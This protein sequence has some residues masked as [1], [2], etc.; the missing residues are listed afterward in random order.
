MTKSAFVGSEWS[1]RVQHLSTVEP[2]DLPADPEAQAIKGQ[3][4]R[5]VTA[6]R[7]AEAAKLYE[8]A[9]ALAPID[10][11][12]Y[13]SLSAVLNDAKDHAAARQALKAGIDKRP[14]TVQPFDGK[15]TATVLKLIGVQNCLLRTRPGGRYVEGGHFSTKYLIDREKFHIINFYV[16]DG[17]LATYS[18]IPKFDIIVN[19]IADPDKEET[20]LRAVADFAKKFPDITIINDPNSVILTT[21]DGNFERLREI[22]GVVIPKTVRISTAGMNANDT[23]ERIEREDFSYPILLREPGW[24]TGITF[25][26]ANN[27]SEVKEYVSGNN[28]D[29]IYVTQFMDS[30][31]KGV[32]ALSRFFT[33]HRKMR[34]LCVDGQI[35]PIVC[36]IDKSWNVHRP[37]GS[38]KA[39][40]IRNRWMREEEFI[41][42]SDYELYI[43][44]DAADTLQRVCAHTELDFFGIDFNVLPDGRVLIFELN[45]AMRH[46]FAHGE[47]FSYVMPQL[48]AV[49][50]GFNRML[51]SKLVAPH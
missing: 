44:S 30:S 27:A 8:Q 42:V 43:G 17:N 12:S 19:S 16:L 9:I 6:G 1:T 33:Y 46:S 39:L 36:H 47:T 11:D 34:V 15:P 37:R 14:Y 18:E 7:F 45:P 32:T 22:P 35:H 3:A 51:L 13:L 31:M 40:M 25:Q 10:L 20:S 26:K 41:F 4:M 48:E 24:H 49:T 28:S 38:Q 23:L 29:E 50:Q 5:L 21:R 2:H